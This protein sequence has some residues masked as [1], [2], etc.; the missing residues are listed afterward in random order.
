MKT[1]VTLVDG[2]KYLAWRCP[3]CK[4]EHIVPVDGLPPNGKAKRPQWSWDGDTDKPTLIPSVHV[5]PAR[6]VHEDGTVF[7]TPR[8]HVFIRAG[9]IEFLGDCTHALAGQTVDMPELE[10][11]DD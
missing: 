6:H 11:S 9:R 5:H 7:E 8:C 3:G 4:T 2:Q 10:D 1:R